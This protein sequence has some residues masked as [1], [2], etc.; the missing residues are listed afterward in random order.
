M[1]SSKCYGLKTETRQCSGSF[2][3]SDVHINTHSSART[4]H[5]CP[6]PPAVCLSSPIEAT[7]ARKLYRT[8]SDPVR[9]SVM[10]LE[11]CGLCVT[12]DNGTG[13]QKQ[14]PSA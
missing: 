7:W 12:I 5:C 8:T 4:V 10:F 6:L 14:E 13:S 11:P 2:K 1:S 9:E 3:L